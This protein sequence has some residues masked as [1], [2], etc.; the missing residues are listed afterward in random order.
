MVDVKSLS[1][2]NVN[3]TLKSDFL[4]ECGIYV[5]FVNSTLSVCMLIAMFFFTR[6]INFPVSNQLLLL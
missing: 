3:I 4:L 6:I 1:L 5:F 2:N